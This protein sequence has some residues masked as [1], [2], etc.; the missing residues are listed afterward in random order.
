MDLYGETVRDRIRAFK[1]S[2][3]SDLYSP[4]DIIDFNFVNVALSSH[5]RELAALTELLESGGL[6]AEGLAST[7]LKQPRLY[8]VL[9]GLLSLN[10]PIEL[11][12]GR[13]LPAASIP[14]SNQESAQNVAEIILELGLGQVLTYGTDV[15]SLYRVVQ[16][17]SDAPR[18]RFRV[19]GK[20]QHRIKAAVEAALKEASFASG[21]EMRL[22]VASTL[23]RPVRR[24]IEH[25][26]EVDGKP[27]IAIAS[28]FQ[29]H[30]GGRQAREMG[31]LYPGVQTALTPSGISMIL[32]A[33][34]QGM[35][36]LSERVLTDLFTA[37]PH[38]MTLAQAGAGALS[39]AFIDVLTAPLKPNVDTAGLN[40]LIQSGLDQ[41]GEVTS[42]LLPVEPTLARLALAGFASAN[43]Q[44]N[45]VLT[46]DG[47][48]LAWLKS[49]LLK[50]FRDLLLHFDGKRAIDGFVALLGSTQEEDKY[51]IPE[52]TTRIAHLDGDKVFSSKF[53]VCA[54]QGPADAEVLRDAA[55]HALQAAPDS[56]VA[57][58]L[59]SD[60]LTQRL[61][62]ELRDVQTFLSVAVVVIDIST[63]VAM[64]KS[65]DA[66]RDH[67]GA[68]LLEQTDLTKLS[69]FV[70]RGVTP[71]RVFFGRQ[72]EEASLLST[73]STNSVA[74]L[75]GRRIGK[76]SLM[77]HSF[78]R[79]TAAN[80]RP[81]F[82][83]CQVVRT[84]ADFGLM[85]ARNWKVKVTSDF[86]PQHLFELVDQLGD[87][88]GRHIVILLDEIDQ[89]LDWDKSHTDDEVPEAF[90][91]ACRSISQQGLAQFVFSGE[92]TIANRLWDATSP[93]WNFCRPLMLRQLN[94]SAAYSLI[95]EPLDA[96]GIRIDDKADFLRS[97]WAATDGHP[98]LLQLLGDRIVA[99]VNHRD[100]SNIFTSPADIAQI[101]DQF[102]YAEQY[103]ETY[104]GQATPLE[105]VI[106][107][108]LKNEP[109]SMD[110]IFDS[111]AEMLPAVDV[112]NVQE[113]LRMLELYGIAHQSDSGYELR[114]LWFNI[115]L[116]F[117]GGPDVAVKRYLQVLTP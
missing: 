78:G 98:E 24:I 113:A 85:A 82:G 76:T 99:L 27:L 37:V 71:S 77:L 31:A 32:I 42:D 17:A 83:D 86:K 62:D 50:E 9:C 108:L 112:R 87:G 49:G 6:T 110:K 65:R 56:R 104:W 88:T 80:L 72:E 12:D 47:S 107:I 48:R 84:W 44:L 79:L 74:L 103:L 63:C 29:T 18:R 91:R 23:P 105:R 67:L 36:S 59:V 28:T 41:G 55:R 57:V 92:R 100:R 61:L 5:H 8:A 34:G 45:L 3:S 46:G 66:A 19:D 102:E 111:M 116:S 101:T 106:S 52:L 35:R 10:G 25:V 13:T 21:R 30:S 73:L 1:T 53:L 96:L 14:P 54:R 40:K 39:K 7:L 70:V 109:T 114:S 89:L 51:K 115:A 16:I 93:H 2:I 117:Y 81:F 97:C 33:D 4:A 64:A 43:N 69:P 26:V 68:L 75:G 11:E 95:S 94:E 90:F 20:V 58:L 60:P 15:S 38:T 22:G